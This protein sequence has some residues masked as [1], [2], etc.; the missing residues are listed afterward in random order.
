MSTINQKNIVMPIQYA[1][2]IAAL[3]VV[4]FHNEFIIHKYY[5]E[6]ALNKFFNA[7]HSG[8]EFFFVLSGY[9]IFKAH[10]T[11]L[12]KPAQAYQFYLKRFIRIFPT[13]WLFVI[14][15][16]LL[17]LTF[18]KFGSDRELTALKFLIDIFL[19]PREGTLILNPAWTLQHEIIFYA[20]FG[21]MVIHFR[22]GLCIFILWQ[23]SCLIG[24]LTGFVPIN[25][26]TPLS[27]FLGFYNFGF[28]FGI[29]I[30]IIEL[31]TSFINNKNILKMISI[32]SLTALTAMFWIEFHDK[33][34]FSPVIS[35]MI[36]FSIYT[37]I[38]LWL[39][40]LSKIS[41]PFLDRY[42]G[43]MGNASYILYLSHTIIASIVVK[44]AIALN[45]YVRMSSL[46]TYILTVV[47]AVALSML[48]YIWIEKPLLKSMK[49][50]SS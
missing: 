12:G 19:I 32:I 31:K 8:V 5:G 16:G 28:L 13:Y 33:F 42:L 37:M 23:L 50:K 9:I 27:K 7:G 21:L 2:G 35:S 26:T 34:K 44:I 49:S 47:S 24:L 25:Y 30:G 6:Y 1:R 20:L 4:L 43:M 45:T 29:T 46:T 15:F 39:L 18:P 36:Y 40:S 22:I 14:P 11:D 48:I 3:M 10:Q 41:R 17:L 38:L